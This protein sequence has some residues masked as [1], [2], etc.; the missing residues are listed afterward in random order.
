MGRKEVLTDIP[1]NEVDKIVEDFE[2]EG[3]SVKKIKQGNGKY[4]VEAT[5]QNGKNQ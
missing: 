4:T 1:E 3:A 5:F 2:S